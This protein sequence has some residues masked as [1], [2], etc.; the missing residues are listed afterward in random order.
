MKK[1]HKRNDGATVL[2][3]GNWK[4]L[5]IFKRPGGF[6]CCVVFD[7]GKVVAGNGYHASALPK[8]F[9]AVRWGCKKAKELKLW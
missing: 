5:E 2:K 6:W 8:K 1:W 3:S 9:N 4:L 7:K